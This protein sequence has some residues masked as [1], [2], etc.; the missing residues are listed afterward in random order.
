MTLRDVV[1]MYGA[2]AD[3][4]D[5]VNGRIYHLRTLSAADENG[6]RTVEYTDID[7]QRYIATVGGIRDEDL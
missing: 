2:I 5:S 1:K 4:R 3:Y 7:G 6:N